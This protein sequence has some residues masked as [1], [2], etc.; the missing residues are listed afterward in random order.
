M[1]IFNLFPFLLIACLSSSIIQA[2]PVL[3]SE[4]VLEIGQSYTYIF[5]DEE[6]VEPGNRGENVIWDFSSLQPLELDSIFIGNT[7]IT[8]YLRQ[9]GQYTIID[10]NTSVFT[11]SFPSANLVSVFEQ[12]DSTISLREET[13]YQ[14][15]ADSMTILGLG[16]RLLTD[17]SVLDRD[18]VSILPF[19]DP[20]VIVPFPFAFGNIFTDKYVYTDRFESSE[21]FVTSTTT[22]EYSS[23][24]TTEADGYG[25]LILPSGTFDDVLRIT[26]R[27]T[28]ETVSEVTFEG[29][30]GS[31]F[32]DTTI[33]TRTTY[34][35]INDDLPSF[36]LI[37]NVETVEDFAPTTTVSYR[38]ENPTTSVQPSLSEQ[39]KFQYYPNL[40]K[41]EITI[42]YQLSKKAEVDISLFD[43]EGKEVQTFVNANQYIGTYRS[44]YSL[45]DLP[46]GIYLIQISI[47][48]SIEFKRLVKQ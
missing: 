33:S 2:Q 24:D 8:N 36:L 6:G 18:S 9:R 46:S 40:S 34:W 39:I 15:N 19:L 25:T 32:S 42:S 16:T 26:K 17:I 41:E 11:D 5:A 44:S 30:F 27:S 1:K 31:G 21:G 22:V 20:S 28:I 10:P 35:W 23:I 3:T 47:D 13:F 14:V 29:D 4:S 37:I 45:A 7:V 48:D 12:E 43:S 38:S